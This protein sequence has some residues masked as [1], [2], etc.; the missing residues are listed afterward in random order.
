MR[1]RITFHKTDAM[2]FTGHL[3]LHRTWERTFRRA[4][5]PLAYSHGFHPQPRINLACAL[6]LGFTSQSEVADIWLQA[7]LPVDVIKTDLEKAVPP[8]IEI[9]SVEELDPRLPA[10]QTQVQSS[11]YEITLLDHTLKLDERIRDLLSCSSLPRERR[12]KI[13]DLRPLIE[14][15]SCLTDDAQGRPRLLVRLAARASAT[16]R[17]E[18]VLAALNVSPEAAR[19]HRTKLIFEPGV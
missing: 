11:E 15:L 1:L 13:Y 18:E 10:L 4:S 5:L 12:G 16:G 6:P 7:D 3:D 9:V 14:E 19:V 17:P 8:G 2:R